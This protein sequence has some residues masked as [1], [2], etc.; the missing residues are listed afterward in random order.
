MGIASRS[1]SNVGVAASTPPAAS[2]AISRDRKLASVQTVSAISPIEGA[3]AIEVARVLGWNVVVKKGEFAVGDRCVY[4][5][6]DSVPPADN[7]AFDFLTRGGAKR[8]KTVRLRGQ[9]SQGICFPTDILPDGSYAEGDDVTDILGITKYDPP[10]PAQLAGQMKGLFPVFIQKTDEPRVQ[11]LDHVLERYAGVPALATEK[12]DGASTTMYINDGEFGVCSRN[13]ELLETPEST[14]W[15]LSHQ[16]AVR[17][18]LE[19]EGR[20]LAIQGEAIGD[21]IQGN[22]Y[23]FPRNDRRWYVYSVFDIDRYRYLGSEEVKSLCAKHGL[24]TVPEVAQ[25]P[26]P[27]SSDELVEMS[28]GFSVLNPQ[29][30]REGIVIRSVEETDVQEIGRLS[31]KAINPDFLLKYDE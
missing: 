18:A 13:I 26:L 14:L 12:L 15:Q 31:V 9:V 17:E 5:E 21:G 25:F 24:V 4:I 28:R 10:I 6:I 19:S 27:G 1:I 20:N 29:V 8:I 22:K 3:D 7:P 2:P 16:Y 30:R 11:S 23:K